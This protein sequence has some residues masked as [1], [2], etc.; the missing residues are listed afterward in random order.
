MQAGLDPKPEIMVPVVSTARELNLVVPRIKAAVAEVLAAEGVQVPIDVFNV[1]PALV[2]ISPLDSFV[3]RDRV[4]YTKRVAVR[5]VRG[6][7]CLDRL[8]VAFCGS[9]GPMAM[10]SLL[11]DGCGLCPTCPIHVHLPVQVDIPVGT[12]IELPRACQTADEIVK[13]KDVKFMSFGT[14]V[15]TC[16]P[17]SDP[18]RIV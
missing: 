2:L 9:N 6:N 4:I 10:L 15:S 14:N 11:S 18:Q 5:C 13:N 8:P 16:I 12:M 17:A 7:W 1:H 3:A